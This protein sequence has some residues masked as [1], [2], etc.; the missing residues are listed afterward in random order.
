MGKEV[1][2]GL[3]GSSAH[4]LTKLKSGRCFWAHISSEVRG[5]LPGSSM[6]TGCW[7]NSVPCSCGAEALIS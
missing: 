7:Q 6:P 2:N 1:G 5:L 3:A 4:G